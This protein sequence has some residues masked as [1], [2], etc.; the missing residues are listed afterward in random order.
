MISTFPSTIPMAESDN[1]LVNLQ[2][3]AQHAV[4]HVKGG[5]GSGALLWETRPIGSSSMFSGTCYPERALAYIGAARKMQDPTL[6]E[7]TAPRL[8]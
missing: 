4:N 7:L 5:H 3:W 1:V 2:R 8:C 6:K